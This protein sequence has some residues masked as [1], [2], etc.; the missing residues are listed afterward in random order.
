ML[1][2]RPERTRRV[3]ARG[4]TQVIGQKVPVGLRFAGRIVTIEIDEIVLR[5]YDERGD[6]LINQVPRT[7]T[8]PLTRFKAYGVTR[9]RTTG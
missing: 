3:S 9:N 6:T 2:R 5:V 4:V 1:D 7:S 8:Q